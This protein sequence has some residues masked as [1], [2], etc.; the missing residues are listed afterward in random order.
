MNDKKVFHLQWWFRKHLGSGGFA[1]VFEGIYGGH[2]VAIKKMKR[3]SKNPAA[4]LEAF[5]A[6]ANLPVLQHPNVIRIF[7]AI[8]DPE[9]LIIMELVPEAL[10]DAETSYDWKI[11]GR[12]LVAALCYIHER[13]ILHLDIKPANIL[14]TQQN[15]CK[16]ADFG[17]SQYSVN[18]TISQLQGTLAYC[19]PELFRGQLPTTKADIYSLAITLWT[20]KTQEAPYQGENNF[21]VV[22]QVVS[23]RR[24][25]SQDPDFEALWDAEPERRPEAALLSLKNFIL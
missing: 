14:L 23:Q 3:S 16:L 6:E 10:I 8:R 19:A 15:V 2:P 25:P 21:M 20:L 11:Y 1:E 9:K 4:V 18:P 24:R 7:A 5:E 22:Y 17:C 12:Q 13:S